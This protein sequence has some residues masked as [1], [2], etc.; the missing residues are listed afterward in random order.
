[1]TL[2]FSQTSNIV[3]KIVVNLTFSFKNVHSL[4]TT[5]IHLL[6]HNRQLFPPSHGFIASPFLSFFIVFMVTDVDYVDMM[7]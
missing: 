3:F 7:H 1:M 4:G 2:T 5:I 6:D